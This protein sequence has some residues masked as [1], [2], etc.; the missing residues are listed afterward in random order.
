MI[1]TEKQTVCHVVTT[2][3]NYTTHRHYEKIISFY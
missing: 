1:E 2:P 3:R